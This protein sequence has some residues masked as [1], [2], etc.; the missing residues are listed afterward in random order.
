[1]FFFL[2]FNFFVKPEE[3]W[4]SSMGYSSLKRGV[5]FFFFFQASRGWQSMALGGQEKT[6]Q[7]YHWPRVVSF[8]ILCCCF[9]WVHKPQRTS[10]VD[11]F[12]DLFGKWHGM[13]PA[14]VVFIYFGQPFGWDS[15][16]CVVQ[17][18]QPQVSIICCFKS[19]SPRGDGPREE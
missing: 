2:I 7:S 5:F 3:D 4:L 15:G 6:S 11:R 19:Q 12:G 18:S 16:Q 8:S 14:S 1:M 10:L 17:E 13:Y 9:F